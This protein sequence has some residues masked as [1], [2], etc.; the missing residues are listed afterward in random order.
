VAFV[1]FVADG[2]MRRRAAARSQTS[3]ETN[4]AVLAAGRKRI[5]AQ[6]ARR[7]FRVRRRIFGT[8]ERPRLAVYRS[9]GHF[10]AQ[11]ID[12]VTGRTLASASTQSKDLR[13]ALKSGGNVAAAKAVGAALAAAAKAKGVA[14]VAFD[15]RHY[16]Y[17]GRVKAFAEAARA[18]GLKF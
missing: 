1:I 4:A 18:G 9:L 11:V 8:A 2:R 16:L 6:R 7:R 3:M 10:Y 12:D 15:R 17:H 13:G 14:Q 5:E